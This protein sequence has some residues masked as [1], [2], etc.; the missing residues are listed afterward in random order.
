MKVIVLDHEPFNDRKR[1]HYFIDNFIHEGIEIEYW[2]LSNV[3]KYNKGYFDIKR[4]SESDFVKNFHSFSD[5]FA[6]LESLNNLNTILIIEV[7]F[8]FTSRK[9]F[10][11]IGDLNLKW[12]RINYYHNPTNYLNPQKKISEKLKGLNF[13]TAFNTLLLYFQN[14]KLISRP[15]AYFLTGREQLDSQIKTYSLDYFDVVK[16]NEFRCR[17]NLEQSLKPLNNYIVFLDIMFPHHPDF[18]RSR[19]KTVSSEIYFKKMRNF[20]DEI[21]EVTGKK[22]I[23]AAHPKSDYN[24]E[25]GNRGVFKNKTLELIYNSDLVLTHGSLSIC[26]A[27][28]AKKPMVYLYFDEMFTSSILKFYYQRMVI[29]S[30][31]TGSVILNIDSYSKCFFEDFKFPVNKEKYDLFLKKVY[32]KSGSEN[33][34][35]YKII[36]EGLSEVLTNQ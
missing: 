4:Y 36:K 35:N 5:V 10:K 25:Y 20:F 17:S 22:V 26:F 6:E 27:L 30:K 11:R 23:I 2:N 1:E 21:E 7:L 14:N 12:V 9:L 34:N 15:S 33:V 32:L 8:H 31:E 13:Y 29:A 3:L 19:V 24:L 16:Y 28:L 18:L